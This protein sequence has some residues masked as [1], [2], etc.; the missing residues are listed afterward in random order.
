MELKKIR[1]LGLNQRVHVKYNYQIGKFG[2]IKLKKIN[3]NTRQKINISRIAKLKIK[4][5]KI[6]YI[7]LREC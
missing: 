4:S 2:I 3:N 7:L 1:K 5:I 6:Y